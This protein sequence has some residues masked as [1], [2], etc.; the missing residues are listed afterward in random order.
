MDRIGHLLVRGRQSGANLLS[1]LRP[2]AWP[3]GTSGASLTPSA[4]TTPE[5]NGSAIASASR[6]IAP[7]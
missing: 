2:L 5:V 1:P 3:P 7:R 6:V 4:V